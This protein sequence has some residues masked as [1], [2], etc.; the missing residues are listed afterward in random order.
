MKNTLPKNLI[1]KISRCAELYT[2]ARK[3]EHDIESELSDLGYDLEKLCTGDGNGF[4]EIERG[5]IP[6]YT[7]WDL[8]IYKKED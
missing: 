6:D 4:E 8:N 2:Q 3:L 1:A 7:T 5:Y